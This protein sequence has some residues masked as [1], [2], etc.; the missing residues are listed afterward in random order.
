AVL[1]WELAHYGDPA[2]DLAMVCIRNLIQPFVPLKEAFGAYVAAGGAPVDLDRVRYY[3]L[4]FQ[5]QFAHPPEALNDMSA[6]AAPPAFGSSLMYG[7]MHMRVLSE[8][9]AEAAHIQLQPVTMPDA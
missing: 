3:R 5:T 1:D 2:A 6:T 7:T 4:Y 9:L 8:A